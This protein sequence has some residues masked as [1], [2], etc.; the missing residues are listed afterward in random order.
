MVFGL[1]F[2]CDGNLHMLEH[3]LALMGDGPI[4]NQGLEGLP[5]SAL[6][7]HLKFFSSSLFIIGFFGINVEV[8]QVV[9]GPVIEGL[10]A[11]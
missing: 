8:L 11:L 10:P 6:K 5:V 9:D 7:H 3:L 1:N 2:G 4:A